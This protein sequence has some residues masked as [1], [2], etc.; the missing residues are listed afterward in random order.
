MTPLFTACVHDRR[1]W[2]PWTRVSVHTTRV[3]YPCHF[4]HPCSLPVSFYTPVFTTRVIL[5]TRVYGPKIWIAE[6]NDDPRIL[7]K[8]SEIA[9]S[10]H[11]QL[12]YGQN[13]G[14]A[15]ESLKYPYLRGNQDR[16]IQ[17]RLWGCFICKLVY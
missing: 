16:Q 9:I 14:N 17:W 13:A 1:F 11:A 15:N 4:T 3:H 10:A 6:S 12:K 2:H 8:R 7:M 5:H